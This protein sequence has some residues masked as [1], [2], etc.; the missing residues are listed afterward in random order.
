MNDIGGIR[1]ALFVP[2]NRPERVDKAVQS[3]A[4]SVIIDLEDAVP[5]AEKAQARTRV[6]EKIQEHAGRALMVRVNALDTALSSLDLAEILV[7]GWTR[8]CCPRCS[9]PRM[10][11]GCT[12]AHGA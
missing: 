1:T 4:D 12:P 2:G 10:S 8:S 9:G 6:R 11:S 7:S 5:L 3:A